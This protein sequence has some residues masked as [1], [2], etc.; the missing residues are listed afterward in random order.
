MFVEMIMICAWFS[1][2]GT[3]REKQIASIGPGGSITPV[4]LTNIIPDDASKIFWQIQSF[5]W[6]L[7]YKQLFDLGSIGIEVDRLIRNVPIYDGNIDEVKISPMIYW[8]RRH[9]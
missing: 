7:Y 4:T 9:H 5:I 6:P 8:L 1:A 2:T 3:N